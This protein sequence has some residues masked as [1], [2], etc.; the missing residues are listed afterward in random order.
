MLIAV[1]SH[2]SLHLKV[3]MLVG[4]MLLQVMHGTKRG[5]ALNTLERV[6]NVVY[7]LDVVDEVHLLC[8]AAGADL[9]R[10]RLCS[11]VHHQEVLVQLMSQVS[12][13][14]TY[15][16]FVRLLLEV[17]RDHVLLEVV[18][19]PEA[20]VADI[21]DEWLLPEV[22]NLHVLLQQPLVHCLVTALITLEGLLLGAA[23]DSP[24]AD[25]VLLSP[26]LPLAGVHGRHTIGNPCSIR[27]TFLRRALERGDS[28]EAVSV[29][30]KEMVAS[31]RKPYQP[32]Q[33]CSEGTTKTDERS[34]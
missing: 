9:A 13:V 25:R 22:D 31:S 10:V 3:W 30:H 28:I 29:V 32:A 1:S 8:E 33:V 17:D 2:G 26:P 11:L 20:R 15:V 4:Q 6:L 16:A 27:R 5:R 23:Q 21:A 19:L 7:V 34:R 24:R 14:A 18:L 12:L